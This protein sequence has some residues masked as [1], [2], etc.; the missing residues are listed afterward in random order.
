MSVEK[1]NFRIFPERYGYFPYVFLIYLFLPAYFIV[2][3]SGWK[4]FIGWG[5]LVLFLVS[6][7]QLYSTFE[8]KAFTYWLIVQIGIILV[9]TN[10]YNL[11]NVFLGFFTSYFLGWYRSNKSFLPAYILFVVSLSLPLIFTYENFIHSGSYYYLVYL[12]IMFIVP[13]G[14][15]SM[16]SRIELEEKLTKANEK[17]EELVKRDERM[18]IARDLH[19]TLGHTL[20]SITL[21]SQLVSKLIEKDWERAG[22]E[23]KEIERTS[24]IALTQ[25]RELVSDMKSVSIAEVLAESESILQSADICYHFEGKTNTKK[26]PSIPQ[27]ILSMCLKEAVTNAVKHSEAKN[28]YIMLKQIAGEIQLI[29]E[30]DGIGFH[31]NKDSGNGLDGMSERLEL[32]DGKL[33]IRAEKGTKLTFTIPIVVKDE[34]V[35]ISS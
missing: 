6:Y 3:E 19:D 12:I 2:L 13:F 8:S 14:I 27:N 16:N 23:A 15:K 22:I 32:V 21:K 29:I 28:C 5:L 31:D 18:R 10:Y 1:W 7:R 4:M 25:V 30:D 9:F 20:S 26:I 24:R 35:G 33:E 34:E 17:I 11:N